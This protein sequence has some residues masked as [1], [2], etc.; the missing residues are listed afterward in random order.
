MGYF[1]SADEVD[2]YVGGIFRLAFAHPRVSPHLAAASSTLHIRVEDP[3]CELTLSLFDSPRVIFGPTRLHADVT[4]LLS[5]D[6]LD[7]YCRGDYNILDALAAGE[8]TA[9]G[10]LSRVLKVMPHMAQLFPVYRA[11]VAPKP[12]TGPRRV[13]Q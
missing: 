4:L 6:Q 2:R 3:A 11:M 13:H 7:R 1:A 10:R 8:I 9:T 5:G 12:L